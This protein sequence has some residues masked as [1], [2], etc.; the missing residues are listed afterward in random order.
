MP[1]SVIGSMEMKDALCRQ[2]PLLA[3]IPN[4]QGKTEGDKLMTLCLSSSFFRVLLA[5]MLLF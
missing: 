4:H 1:F 2:E 3:A 5:E